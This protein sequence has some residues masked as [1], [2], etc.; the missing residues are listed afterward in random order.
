MPY[1]H[2]ST[3][4]PKEKI[5]DSCLSDLSKIV[6]ESLGKP[7]TFVSVHIAPD[8]MLMFGGSTD[9]CGMAVLISIGK[10]GIEENK[11]HSAKLSDYIEKNLGIPKNRM[12]INF[13]DKE[14]G[15][16][17]FGGSTFHKG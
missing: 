4:L 16:V 7:E 1:F 3:N 12:Y 6:S 11:Q 10:L 17:G 2:L 14:R 5:P 13:V 8:Q 9:P 15:D